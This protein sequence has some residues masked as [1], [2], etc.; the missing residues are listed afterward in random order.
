MEVVDVE[1]STDQLSWSVS[2]KHRSS[3]LSFFDASGDFPI[4]SRFYF[5]IVLKEL[6]DKYPFRLVDRL[7]GQ[8]LWSAATNRQFTDVEFV[9]GGR[10]FHA[11]RAIVAA[12]S[13]YFARM[14]NPDEKLAKYEIANCDP[15]SFEQLLFFM[16]T[17]GLH[18]SA[19]NKD[20]LLAAREYEIAT[21]QTVCERA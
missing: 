6:H 4:N 15:T 13:P 3:R 21:L 19:D 17:S 8:Q 5:K 9:V 12:R 1:Y 14:F 11:H 20:L 10:S 16:Y 18:A 2:F 7:H